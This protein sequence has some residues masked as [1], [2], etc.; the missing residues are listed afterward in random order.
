IN[1][2]ITGRTA[3][4][5]ITARLRSPVP[6]DVNL[7]TS[8]GSIEV[9]VPPD[10]GLDVEAESSSGRVTSDLP[11][12]G[13]RTDREQLKGK[14]NGGGKSMVLR[15]GGGSISFKPSLNEVAVN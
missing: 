8:A 14:I 10:A 4:G 3:G 1:G 9:T 11:F 2:K 7:E 5:S 12:V 15:S 13:I 6:G